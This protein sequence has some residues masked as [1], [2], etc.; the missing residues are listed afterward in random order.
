M[1]R[2]IELMPDLEWEEALY[3]DKLLVQIAPEKINTFVAIY[4]ARRKDPKVV[5]ICSLIGFLGISGVHRFLLGHIGIGLLYLLTAG[6]CFIGTIV[7]AINYQKL[8]FEANTRTADE[9]MQM[10]G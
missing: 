9:V 10:L 2:A 3:V 8:A 5:L 7:D 4:R 6:L 1:S